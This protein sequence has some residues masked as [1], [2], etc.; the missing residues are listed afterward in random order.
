MSAKDSRGVCVVCGTIRP[1]GQL[2]Y[3]SSD[4]S[5]SLSRLECHDRDACARRIPP[6]CP[7]PLVEAHIV[8]ALE[9]RE[10]FIV[11]AAWARRAREGAAPGLVDALRALA[12]EYGPRGVALAAATLMRPSVLKAWLPHD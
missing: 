8:S 2:R 7:E 11:D 6:P 12:D 4:A 5:R 10:Q 1:L 9:Q 3:A